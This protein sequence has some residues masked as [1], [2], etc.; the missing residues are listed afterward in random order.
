MCKSKAEGGGRCEYADMI[1]NVRK[2]AR[3]KYRG[4]Y[5]RERKATEAVNAW[6]GAHPEIVRAHLPAKMPF[7][8]TPKDRPVPKELLSML[9]PSSRVPVS[10]KTTP[11]ERLQAV[12]EMHEEFTEWESRLHLDELRAVGAYTMSSFDKINTFLRKKG[13][14]HKLK[15][16]FR[17]NVSEYEYE[18]VKERTEE[19]VDALK[20]AFKK[21]APREE[22]RKLYRFFRVPAG[23]TP[24]EYV[25]RYLQ[26]GEGFRDAAF[27]STTSDPEF[28]M[29][30]MHDRNKGVKNKAYVVMEILTKQGQSVQPQPYTRAGHVQSLENE[31]LLPA[32]TKLRVAGFNPIQRFEYGSDRK[33]LH[34]QYNTG[35]SSHF[36]FEHYGHHS[37]GDRLTF[38]MVQLIDEKLITEYEKEEQRKLK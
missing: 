5:D 7:Q 31:V 26:T 23:V 32:G 9:T 27:M 35:H 2:K 30:H 14:L 16:D 37:K 15:E 11:E 21:V 8:F 28:I 20:S 1:A 29:A 12:I 10:G 25:E 24:K 22:P 17:G 19:Q 4:E 3:Y 18:R 38:P 36:M 13:F 33:D 34:G 6:K